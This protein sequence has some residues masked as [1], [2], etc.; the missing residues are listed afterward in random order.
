MEFVVVPQ[1]A[2]FK[3]RIDEV[4]LQQFQ[5]IAIKLKKDF[6]C[7]SVEED[8]RNSS[9]RAHE[10]DGTGDDRGGRRDRGWKHGITRQGPRNHNHNHNHNYNHHTAIDSTSTTTATR[11]RI[12]LQ[13]MSTD[14][15]LQRDIN[16]LL[17]KLTDQNESVIIPKILKHVTD[18]GVASIH[19]VVSSV[20]KMS[21]LSPKYQ[22]Y[23]V[24]L[25]NQISNIQDG[26]FR[27]LVKD[28]I[29]G[30]WSTY[31]SE[32]GWLIPTELVTNGETESEDE[33]C[34]YVA[35][36]KQAVAIIELWC[37]LC[38]GGKCAPLSHADIKQ[39]WSQ[40]TNEIDKNW[41]LQNMK[42]V[43]SLLE[44][45]MT[46]LQQLHFLNNNVNKEKV[47]S[48]QTRATVGNTANLVIPGAMRFRL[49]DILE[50][51]RTT[52]TKNIKK[53][54]VYKDSFFSKAKHDGSSNR[55]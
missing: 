4:L 30:I 2:F 44:L 14:M 8:H 34:G 50:L 46:M 23:Y 15:I 19:M 31:M 55:F 45:I 52:K 10:A 48:W 20:W 5:T 24:E 17:N 32:R 54:L 12:G 35:W 53:G 33:F 51:L 49:M 18:T 37:K 29:K 1:E 38:I 47:G 13:E 28:G 39:L 3:A 22:V 6:A 27:D 9:H 41:A 21:K 26:V 11:P 36:K 7:F 16:S 42:M 25:L 43:D 40:I